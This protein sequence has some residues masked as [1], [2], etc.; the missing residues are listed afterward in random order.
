MNMK[1][2]EDVEKGDGVGP[3]EH[4]EEEQ[5]PKTMD[6][7]EQFTDQQQVYE[8]EFQSA[9]ASRKLHVA[10]VKIREKEGRK[11][12]LTAKEEQLVA[13]EVDVLV[14]E[15]EFGVHKALYQK[16]SPEET[17]E[18]RLAAQAHKQE[19]LDKMKREKKAAGELVD[20]PNKNILN[21]DEL[22]ENKFDTLE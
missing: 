21:F 7:E 18:R 12:E 13:L 1:T 6:Y 3:S 22:E 11:R 16:Q 15:H 4:K 10:K 8:Q 20:K 9:I 5:K 14:G 2:L 19:E 17:K